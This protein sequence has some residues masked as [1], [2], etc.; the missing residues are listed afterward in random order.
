MDP[1]VVAHYD[2]DLTQ[3]NIAPLQA[4]EDPGALRVNGREPRPLPVAPLAKEHVPD[5]GPHPFPGG[6]PV[7]V[8]GE[9]LAQQGPGDSGASTP[10]RRP[11]AESTLF[12]LIAVGGIG[13]GVLGRIE[14]PGRIAKVTG[15]IADNIFCNLIHFEKESIC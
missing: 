12:R 7:V 9:R 10:S 8:P 13:V 11:C 6:G 5:E 4:G 2:G 15:Y 14:S 1:K 3:A